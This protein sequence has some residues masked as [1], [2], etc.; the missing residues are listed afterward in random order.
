MGNKNLEEARKHNP[1]LTYETS[2]DETEEEIIKYVINRNGIDM[3]I[4]TDKD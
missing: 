2:Y 4:F 3:Y 1:L